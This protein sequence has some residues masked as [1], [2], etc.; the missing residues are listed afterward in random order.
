MRLWDR[1]VKWASLHPHVATLIVIALLTGF[2]ILNFAFDM[3]PMIILLCA[4]AAGMF[5]HMIYFMV[6]GDF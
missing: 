1:W 4:F 3:W 5:Y 2:F 6:S